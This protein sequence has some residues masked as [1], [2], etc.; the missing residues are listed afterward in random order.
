[1]SVRTNPVLLPLISLVAMLALSGVLS[2]A[3]TPSSSLDQAYEHEETRDLVALVNDA[4]DLIQ[5]KGEA[6]FTELSTAGSRWRQSDTYIFV[7]DPQGNMLVHPD[8]ALEGKNVIDLKDI[9]G[10]PIVRGLIA[11]ATTV[12]TKQEGWYHYE[13]PVPNGLLPRWKSTF[14]RQVTV[15]SGKQYIVGA[16][17][18]NDRMERAFVVDTVKNAAAQIESK[19]E[20]A[21][22]S[23]RDPK[24]PYLAKDTYIF[25]IKPD[26]VEIVNPAFPSIEGRNLTDLK[27]T[28][29]KRAIGEMLTVV[30]TKGSGWVDYMWPKPGESVSTQK[31]AFVTKAKMG[32]E[33]V[34]VGCGVYLADAPKTASAGTETTAPELMS[35][36]R[37]AAALLEQQ[38]AEAYPAFREKDS[39]WNHDNTYVFVWGTDGTRVF[40]A[41]DPGKEGQNDAHITDSLGRPYGRMFLEAA[42]SPSGEGWVHYMYPEPGG[43]FPAWK[44]TFVKRV[45]YPDGK[46]HI[47]GSGIYNM[48]M[49]KAFIQD[50]VSRAS[51]VVAQEGEAG[52]VKLR[53]KTG[54]YFFMDTYVFVITPEGLEVVNPGQPS[55]EGTNIIDLKDV[56][57]K[58]VIRQCIQEAMK[59]GGG[60]VDYYWYK[61]GDN[62]PTHKMTYVQKIQSGTDTYIVGSG[63]YT[64]EA[65]EEATEEGSS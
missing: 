25:V 53:D 45:T 51:A 39:K 65:A 64:E 26:G 52:F 9:N 62:T 21:F 16:G 55:M 44:S 2:R 22:A 54:P 20:A 48:K 19:G 37:E 13:W 36:V 10:K 18:Y 17:M 56:H 35:L 14:V 58:D 40:H 50:V 1:M 46:Q 47:V 60:W 7:L 38:G 5:A 6:G 23:F 59:N 29:G 27:D 42:N 41:A 28:Q 33:W 12:P 49:D 43:I 31:S 34:L 32:N 63:F 30:N 3:A 15:P 24:G 11:A 4:A 57:G 8:P 61:P